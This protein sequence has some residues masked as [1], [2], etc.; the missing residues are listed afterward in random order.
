MILLIKDTLL[1]DKN[2]GHEHM[3][4]VPCIK[5]TLAKKEKF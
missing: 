2:I 3:N 1:K 5:S 4:T